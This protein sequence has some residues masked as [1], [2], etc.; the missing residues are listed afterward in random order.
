MS[1]VFIIHSSVGGCLG[2]FQFLAMM[3]RAAMSMVTGISVVGCAFPWVCVHSYSYSYG[4][5]PTVVRLDL[6]ADLFPASWRAASL[7]SRV[8]LYKSA[9]PPCMSKYS[10]CPYY[11][12]MLSLILLILAILT[13][14]RCPGDDGWE[15]QH[16]L[17]LSRLCVVP[18]ENWLVLFHIF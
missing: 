12:F 5:V 11:C 18:F 13:G 2:F 15:S 17:C 7:V 1:H 16:C 8:W 3:S 14:V 4:C 6:R 10:F 9:L